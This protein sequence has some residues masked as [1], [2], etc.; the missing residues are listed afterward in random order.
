MAHIPIEF[1]LAGSMNIHTGI[2]IA[3]RTHLVKI[4]EG[5]V[6][7]WYSYHFVD[8]VRPITP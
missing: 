5:G 4:E 6:E 7:T 8:W 1:K 2:L 3:S